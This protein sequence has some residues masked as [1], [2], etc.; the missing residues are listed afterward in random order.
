VLNT[1]CNPTGQIYTEAELEPV[2][3]LAREHGLLV[4][5]D[6]IYQRLV[7]GQTKHVSIVTQFDLREQGVIVSGVSKTYAMTGWRIG[8]AAG[9]AEIIGAMTRIQS[10]STSCAN[11]IA[12]RAALAALSG[13][14]EELTGPMIREFDK[15]RMYIITRLKNISGIS[16]AEPA[17]AF[18]AFPK[19]SR[20]Y[21]KRAATGQITDSNSFAAALLEQHNVV[22]VPGIAFGADEYVRMSYALGIDEIEKGL[23]R[24]EEFLSSLK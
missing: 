10:H 5:S 16:V 21:G 22:V 2:A 14:A 1:P 23:D 8:Y 7:Y 18:F 24:F 4:V 19:V 13:S 12:Q 6:E 20:Y 15:R 17:G 11:A 3:E 9:P